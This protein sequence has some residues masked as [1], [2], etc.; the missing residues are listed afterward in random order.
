[1]GQGQT[2]LAT[3]PGQTGEKLTFASRCRLP[4]TQR[5]KIRRQRHTQFRTLDAARHHRVQS[6]NG[7]AGQADG[8]LVA[9]S[10]VQRLPALQ[11]THT[12]AF[13]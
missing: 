12:D 5:M 3:E 2:L 13:D 8:D 10:N 1:M 6:G 9:R 4:T 7:Q 11:G